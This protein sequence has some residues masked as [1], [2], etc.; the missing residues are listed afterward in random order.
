MK[1]V[2][3]E[4]LVLGV[5]AGK[6]AF[7]YFLS[8]KFLQKSPHVDRVFNFNSTIDYVPKWKR[9]EPTPLAMNKPTTTRQPVGGAPVGRTDWAAK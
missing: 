3:V 9:A 1:T 8:A 4:L 2:V 5:G 7:F 6:V